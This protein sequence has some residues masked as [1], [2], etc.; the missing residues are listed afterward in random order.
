MFTQYVTAGFFEAPSLWIP[1]FKAIDKLHWLPIHSFIHSFTH[2]LTH[3]LDQLDCRPIFSVLP[4]HS[5]PYCVDSWASLC[6]FFGKMVIFMY[7][8]LYLQIIFQIQTKYKYAP[9]CDF[10]YKYNKCWY[11]YKM[12]DIYSV[13]TFVTV[14]CANNCY[15]MS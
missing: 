5:W 11:L 13:W 8:W 7:I 12:S 14:D 1:A 6:H 9:F 10:Q 3:S 15:Y 4:A 2:S